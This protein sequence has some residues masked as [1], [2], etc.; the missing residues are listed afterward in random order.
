MPVLAYAQDQ[1]PDATR[2]ADP[3]RRRSC[4]PMSARTGRSSK[5]VTIEDD[6]ATDISSFRRNPVLALRRAAAWVV[7]Y[8]ASLPL[9]CCHSSEGSQAPG[10]DI[11]I[12]PWA[13]DE[14]IVEF[15]DG[16]RQAS[17]LADEPDPSDVCGTSTQIGQQKQTGLSFRS[18][19]KAGVRTAGTPTRPGREN[20]STSGQS[21]GAA[22]TARRAYA[23]SFAMWTTG[24]DRTCL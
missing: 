16:Q 23:S 7:P 15:P 6:M 13:L 19:W 9:V 5:L 10:R 14:E 17:F 20:A 8:L 24:P 4:G 12:P 3:N 22:Q 1:K 18:T 11:P 2:N 21:T